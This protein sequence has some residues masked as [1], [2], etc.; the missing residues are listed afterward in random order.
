MHAVVRA[1]ELSFELARAALDEVAPDEV[2]LLDALGLDFVEASSAPSQRDG[3]LGF[4]VTQVAMA[5]AA[6]SVAV[7]VKD[8][9]LG[10]VEA[11][12]TDQGAEHLGRMVRRLKRR[13]RTANG[14]VDPQGAGA[15]ADVDL[16]PEE[17]S[18]VRRRAFVHA[19]GLG[20]SQAKADLLADAITGSLRGSS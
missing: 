4:D 9:L 18:E 5:V 7:A 15:E 12:A 10:T 3:A 8:Y 6:S 13:R 20:L 2:P 1:D 14:L 17:I 19:R 11:F 16:S